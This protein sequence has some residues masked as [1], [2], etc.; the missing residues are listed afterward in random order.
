MRGKTIALLESRLGESMAS[1][2]ER[3]GGIAFRAP[4]LAEVPDIDPGVIARLL[5]EWPQDPPHAVIFQTGVGTKALFAAAAQLQLTDT[6]QAMLGQATILVRGAKPMAALRGNGV[7]VDLAAA[8]PYTTEQLLPLLDG[9]Q[10]KGARVLVQRHGEANAVLDQALQEKGARVTEIPV[11]RW[12]LPEDRTP[13]LAL[14]DALAA[15]RID[16]VAFTSAAQAHNLFLLADERG[17]TAELHQSLSR[18][19]VVSIGPAC[20]KA[21]ARLGIPVAAEADPPKLGPFLEAIK[22]LFPEA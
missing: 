17:R 9:L 11:Y 20:S 15:G 22:A 6:L 1:L 16:A 12:S 5:T 2:V 18:V 8:S 14:M 13:L 3:E 21:L 19:P 7:R 4:A 10:L